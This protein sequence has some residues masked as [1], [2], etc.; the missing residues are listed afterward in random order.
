MP[1]INIE[2]TYALYGYAVADIPEGKEI[3]DVYIKWNDVLIEFTDG[4][5]MTFDVHFSYEDGDT[6]RPDHIRVFDEDYRD[7]IYVKSE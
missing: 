5:E 6:K 3:K 7:E 1:S 2:A 4:T